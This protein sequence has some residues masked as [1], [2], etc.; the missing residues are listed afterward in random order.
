MQV[1][2]GFDQSTKGNLLRAFLGGR[3]DCSKLPWHLQP[4]AT[5][6]ENRIPRQGQV[7][8]LPLRLTGRRLVTAAQGTAGACA[9]ARARGGAREGTTARYQKDSF[10][11]FL[12]L[13]VVC[14]DTLDLRRGYEASLSPEPSE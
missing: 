3:L 12:V 6:K 2:V 8:S 13:R 11:F 7:A 5:G 9:S 14:A 4:L 10:V 1:S